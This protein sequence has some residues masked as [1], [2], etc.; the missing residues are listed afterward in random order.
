MDTVAALPTFEELRRFV[1]QSL[2]ERDRLDPEQTPLFEGVVTRAGRPVGLF[3]QLQG[4]R[5]LKTYAIWAGEEN[6]LLF[7]DSTGQR[8]GEVSL[9]EAP[10]PLRLKAAA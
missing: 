1:R 8:F 4:T 5:L 3:Y 7:Y 10:D 6:R 9:S 2:C